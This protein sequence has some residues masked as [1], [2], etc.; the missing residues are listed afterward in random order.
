MSSVANERRHAPAVP[1]RDTKARL[2]RFRVFSAINNGSLSLPLARPF[3]SC[4]NEA[5]PPLNGT[6]L[7]ETAAAS[8][9]ER[10]AA[11]E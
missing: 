4:L 1:L 6:A 3:I 2:T 7:V 5:P 10:I 9:R 11:L 8:G